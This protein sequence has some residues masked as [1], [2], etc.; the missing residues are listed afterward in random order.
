[1]AHR[2]FQAFQQHGIGRRLTVGELMQAP[3]VIGD[4]GLFTGQILM[5]FR[6]SGQIGGK[7]SVGVVALQLPAAVAGQRE[8]TVVQRGGSRR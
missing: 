8:N 5:C 2:A 3:Q 4:I 1:M 6:Q 7:Q